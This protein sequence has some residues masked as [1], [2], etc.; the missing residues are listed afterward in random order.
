LGGDGGGFVE[1][2]GGGAGLGRVFEDADVFEAEVGDEA[3]ELFVLGVG[4]AGEAG[5]EGGAEGDAGDP[6]AE[7]A[8]KG[9]DLFAGDLRRMDWRMSSLMCWR[10]MSM[11]FT[12]LRQSARVLIISSVKQEG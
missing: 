8:E 1:A 10:G 11:Y 3:E 7:F 9:F 2:A 12:T 4:F 5:D 6:V